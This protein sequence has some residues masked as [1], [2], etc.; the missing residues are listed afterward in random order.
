MSDPLHPFDPLHEPAMSDRSEPPSRP[1]SAPPPARARALG[2]LWTGATLCYLAAA[3]LPIL[4]G[5]QASSAIAPCALGAA[6]ALAPI[7]QRPFAWPHAA[8][9]AAFAAACAWLA[10]TLVLSALLS[11]GAL[12]EPAQA[13]ILA[14]AL[15]RAA[16]AVGA[17][18]GLGLFCKAPNAL[19]WVGAL[20]CAA[21]SLGMA[22][23]LLPWA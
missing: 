9:G 10:W 18:A 19:S 17:S 14:E 3:A 20:A 21:S 23:P 16:W 11:W 6:L 12:P 5:A 7:F 2:W 8:A 13:A 1:A 22:W 15:R 4:D